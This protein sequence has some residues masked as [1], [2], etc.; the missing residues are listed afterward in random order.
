MAGLVISDAS[1]PRGKLG[2]TQSHC[3]GANQG[4]FRREWRA[5]AKKRN[6]EL[7]RHSGSRRATAQ[8]PWAALHSLEL[9]TASPALARL[10]HNACAAA[11]CYLICRVAH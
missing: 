11:E 7:R 8:A 6:A 4:A 10:T 1:G 3:A 5:L 9:A 2:I